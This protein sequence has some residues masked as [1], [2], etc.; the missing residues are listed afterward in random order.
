MF[1]LGLSELCLAG[2]VALVVLGPERLPVVARKA[3]EWAGKIR[4]M[5]SGVKSDWQLRESWQQLADAKNEMAQAASDIREQLQEQLNDNLP[6]WERLPELKTPADFGIQE[7]EPGPWA[8][9]SLSKQAMW[10]KRDMRPRY[11]P[12]PK[13]RSRRER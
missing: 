3:G 4:R 1:D 7:N 10:R 8:R 9:S 13:L 12:K 6:A 11:R 2:V 5:A